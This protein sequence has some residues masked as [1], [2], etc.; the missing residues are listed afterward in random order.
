M[1]TKLD[2]VDIDDDGGSQIMWLIQSVVGD[3][4]QCIELC[5]KLHQRRTDEQTDTPGIEFGAF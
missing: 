2:S 4:Y 1:R 3:S 5:I